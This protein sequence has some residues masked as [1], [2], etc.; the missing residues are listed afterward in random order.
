METAKEKGYAKVIVKPA[1]KNLRGLTEN[2]TRFKNIAPG[3]KFPAAG[4]EADLALET[5]IHST[6]DSVLHRLNGADYRLNHKYGTLP[7]L[8]LDVSPGALALLPGFPEVLSI[9]EDRA[10]RLKDPLSSTNPG[11]NIPF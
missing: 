10:T 1:V 6:A 9:Y 3:R 4:I 2:S 7:Y 5:A 8:A 11:D